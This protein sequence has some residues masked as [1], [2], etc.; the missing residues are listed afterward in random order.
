MKLAQD[1]LPIEKV[2]SIGREL[3]NKIL[4]VIFYDFKIGD[5]FF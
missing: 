1:V 5:F 4:D 3:M 2:T